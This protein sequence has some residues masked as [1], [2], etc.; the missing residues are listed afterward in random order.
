MNSNGDETPSASCGETHDLE[1][2]SALSGMSA[3]LIL[4]LS[5]WRLIDAGTETGSLENSFDMRSIYR[6]RQIEI[7][8]QECSLGRDSLRLVAELVERLDAAE[9]ELRALRERGH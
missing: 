3:D 7:F 2:A 1:S 6:L 8:R 5:R 4:E 9:R